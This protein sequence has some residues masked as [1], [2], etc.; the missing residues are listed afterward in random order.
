MSK[1]PEG[2]Q[3]TRGNAADDKHSRDKGWW[4]I[5]VEYEVRPPV[6]LSE[7]IICPPSALE[8]LAAFSVGASLVGF[9]ITLLWKRPAGRSA[10]FVLWVAIGWNALLAITFIYPHNHHAIYLRTHRAS[11]VANAALGAAWFAAV[12]AA[13]LMAWRKWRAV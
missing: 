1:L 8:L 7:C 12:A 9:A 11:L 5:N 13:L 6:D 3:E 2:L 4:R 10:A